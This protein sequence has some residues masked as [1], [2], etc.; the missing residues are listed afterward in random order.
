MIRFIRPCCARR[1]AVWGCLL[2]C[3]LLSCAPRQKKVYERQRD[4]VDS[5]LI[6]R[7]DSIY[8][9][10]APDFITFLRHHI[11]HNDNQ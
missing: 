9:Y 1:L 8:T 5:L 7:Y 6:S 4:A 10:P 3:V 11:A 2:L